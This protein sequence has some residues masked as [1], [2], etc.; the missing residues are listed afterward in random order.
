MTSDSFDYRATIDEMMPGVI[1]DRRHL[2][3]HPELAFQEHETAAFVADRLAS[4]G[5]EDIRTGIGKTGVTGLIEG[6]GTRGSGKVLMLRADMD[7]LPILEENEVDYVSQHPGV[8]HACGHDSHVSMLLGTT[9]VLME[10]RG[11]FA[12]TVKVLFQPA[13]EGGGGAKAMRAAGALED[14][15]VDAAMG[16]HIWQDVPVGQVWVRDNTAMA[17]VTGFTI[18]VYGRGGHGAR[19]DITVDP[20]VIGSAIVNGLLTLVSREKNP[21]VPAVVS[22]GSF[23]S[24]NAAN[25]I[26][27]TA[28][29]KGTI[30]S[31]TREQG[32]AV[33]MRLQALAEGIAAS[34][35]ARTEIEFGGSAPPLINDPE[36]AQLVRDAVGEG[37]G[38]DKV[39][40]GNLMTVSEDFGEFLDPVP[41]CFFFVGSRNEEK[42]F[43]YGHH[44]PKFDI[45]EEGMAVGI[46]S[47]S[48]AAVKYLQS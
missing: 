34:M 3:Q 46:E 2:H 33:E 43:V 24:G 23:Q 22:V 6:T 39:S 5:V 11:D 19:P 44:H 1:A 41:G 28:V 12:G 18:T 47:M 40:Q 13:E 7:A 21:V 4:L 8:M 31:V 42:G 15:K 37:I 16:L 26:P 30:R 32:E 14:P 48:R 25:V 36:I 29:L 27:D 9:K 20:I 17:G 10:R 45:D 38:A 35:G